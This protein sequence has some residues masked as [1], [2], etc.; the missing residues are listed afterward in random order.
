MTRTEEK[1]KLEL[2]LLWLSENYNLKDGDYLNEIRND[3][4]I[5]QIVRE[6]L[7]KE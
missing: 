2:F 5:N 1:E 3:I 4:T 6:Y 7:D